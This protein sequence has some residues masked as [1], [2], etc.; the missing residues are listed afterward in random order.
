MDTGELLRAKVLTQAELFVHDL[1]QLELFP[2]GELNLRIQPAGPDG[3][4]DY[5]DRPTLI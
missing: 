5:E 4:E 3:N 1:R 2:E